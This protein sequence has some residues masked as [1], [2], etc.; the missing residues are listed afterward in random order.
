M[1]DI[2]Q[3]LAEVN[4][5]ITEAQDRIGVVTGSR[6]GTNLKDRI[7]GSDGDDYIDGGGGN[8][9]IFGNFGNDFLL[10]GTGDDL[11][12]GGFGNDYVDGGDGNDR[13]FGDFGDDLVFG[14]N[15][16][17]LLDG[18][19]GSDVLFGGDGNDNITGGTNGDINAPAGYFE[20][21]L[22][23]GRGSDTLNGF[24]GGAGNIEV[25]WLIGGGAV[26]ENGF[27]TDT[28]PDGVRDTFVLGNSSGAFY[29]TAG[30]ND[31]A[32]IFD[33][34]IGIDQLQLSTSVTH[35][36]GVGSVFSDRDTLIFANLPNG[37]PDLIGVVVGVD[38]IG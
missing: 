7:F 5:R 38:L 24:G 30:L 10:G 32:V 18:G 9:Q 2:E 34:E 20:D 6:I 11:V 1:L 25:D 15:G 12:T 8:D 22:I 14:G 16:N 36:F 3:I 33:F 31:Y 26:D 23:G 35:T 27:I 21:Y 13:L 37:T 4:Q 17:D 29:A 28:S 19:V